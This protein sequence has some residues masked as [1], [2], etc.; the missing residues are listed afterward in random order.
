MQAWEEVGL[1]QVW[2]ERAS[3]ALDLALCLH[4]G[5]ARHS[6]SLPLAPP[7]LHLIHPTIHSSRCTCTCNMLVSCVDH[8]PCAEHCEDAPVPYASCT[9]RCPMVMARCMRGCTL[10]LANL[11]SLP[12]ASPPPT[13]RTLAACPMPSLRAHPW[14]PCLTC[15]SASAGTSAACKKNSKTKATRAESVVHKQ[16]GEECFPLSRHGQG[17]KWTAPAKHA[18]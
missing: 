18:G 9:L 17:R 3:L 4:S 16:A 5:L 11:P 15:D 1:V 14:P 13:S 7:H 2:E 6:F 8:C 10:N 12:F